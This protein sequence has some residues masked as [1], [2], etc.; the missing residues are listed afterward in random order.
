[1]SK[2]WVHAARNTDHVDGVCEKGPVSYT[3]G[4]AIRLNAQVQGI[5][6]SFRIKLNVQ[7]H[8]EIPIARSKARCEY[9]QTTHVAAHVHVERW[10]EGRD[11][12]H[13]GVPLRPLALPPPKEPRAHPARHPR[14]WHRASEITMVVVIC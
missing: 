8:F 3:T 1:M 10:H 7:V 13:G 14:T 2:T 6:P 11:G 9:V 12:P 4:A 5:G